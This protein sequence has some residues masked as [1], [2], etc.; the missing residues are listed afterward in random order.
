MST[1][2]SVKKEPVQDMSTNS[3]NP[4]TDGSG[5]VPQ[6]DNI[7]SEP[8]FVKELRRKSQQTRLAPEVRA[9]I[10]AEL[11]SDEEQER[12]Y[13]EMQENGGMSYEEFMKSLGL[14]TDQDATSQQSC[15][16]PRFM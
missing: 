11:P 13:R 2:I 12:L 1:A 8:E 14:E 10:L 6:P 9:Q 5:H 7:N 16:L 15:L 3:E 4:R